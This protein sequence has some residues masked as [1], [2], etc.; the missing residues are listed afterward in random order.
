MPVIFFDEIGLAEQSSHNPLKI[1]HNYLEIE[2]INFAFVG[3]SNYRL[4]ASKMNRAIFI[5]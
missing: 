5:G 1:L 2:N 3:I 4:D